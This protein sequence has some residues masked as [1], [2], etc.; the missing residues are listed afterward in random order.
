MKRY[1][2]LT[3]YIINFVLL[4]YTNRQNS[5]AL[6]SLASRD[7]VRLACTA[8]LIPAFT[9]TPTEPSL[10]DGL[11]ISS[12]VGIA[13]VNEV[14]SKKRKGTLK[15]LLLPLSNWVYY[16]CYPGF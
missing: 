3:A 11:I 6:P 13:S 4:I 7:T 5:L 8:P 9:Q 12:I 15:E 2:V 14:I 1:Y 10:S 16:H